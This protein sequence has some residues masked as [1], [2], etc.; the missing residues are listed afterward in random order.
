M[1]GCSQP[2]TQ[3][4]MISISR[5]NTRKKTVQVQENAGGFLFIQH[6]PCSL[7]GKRSVSRI[8]SS[9]SLRRRHFHAS[10]RKG[11]ESSLEFQDAPRKLNQVP[12]DGTGH[13]QE[14]RKVA[15]FGILCCQMP[16]IAPKYRQGH[17]VSTGKGNGNEKACRR[18]R[19][20][21]NNLMD[22]KEKRDAAGYECRMGSV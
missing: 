3:E 16:P 9:F 4:R 6:W 13:F 21:Q 7:G 11:N 15:L 2:S 5:T 1:G 14:P 12:E 10:H 18:A 17:V 22:S 19:K 8:I 20:K